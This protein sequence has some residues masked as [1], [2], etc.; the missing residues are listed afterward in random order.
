MNIIF[1]KGIVKLVY[2]KN[3]QKTYANKKT[4]PPIFIMSPNSTIPTIALIILVS[5]N[6]SPALFFSP[7]YLRSRC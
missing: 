4:Q 6:Y 2:G 7:P 5:I 1:F 3:I